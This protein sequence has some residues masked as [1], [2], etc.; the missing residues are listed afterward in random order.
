MN[1]NH[2]ELGKEI[3]DKKMKDHSA[4]VDRIDKILSAALGGYEVTEEEGCILFSADESCGEKIFNVADQLRKKSNGNK[5][6]FIVNR[7]I[8]F[9]NICYMGC[10]FCNFA[11]RKQ[12]LGSELL[13]MSTIVSRARE[14]WD[15]G[16]T[17]VCIQGGLN[18]SVS[19]D[20]YRQIVLAIKKQLPGLHIH[21]FSPFEIWYG[22]K[23]K[24]MSYYAFLKD[25]VDCGLGSIPGTAAEILDVDVRNKLTK[26]KLSSDCWTEIIKTAHSLNLPS[27]ATIMYGHIDQPHHWAMHIAKLREIQKETGGFTE[28]V[29]LSFVHQSSPLYKEDPKNVRPGPTLYEV[30]KMHAV[31]RIML[32]GWINNIQV[33]WTKLGPQ[34]AQLML[35]LGV[36]DLGGTLMNESISRSAGSQ[37]G[38]E[39]TPDEMVKI[40]REAGKVPVRRNTRYGIEEIFECHDPRKI[41]PLV[42]RLVEPLKFLNCHSGR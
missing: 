14:A 2:F 37:Y 41:P 26:N 22:S 3:K 28:L 33:S 1:I 42:P 12:Q 27:T 35:G 4:F 6:S 7:N 36:N 5:V 25:L 19:G 8:N 31:S 30:K 9:T 11:K 20:I 34:I 24:K 39:I 23:K 10:K 15:R 40:I 21:A 17:E 38:Q 32:S 18:P 29:P 13:S 16:A